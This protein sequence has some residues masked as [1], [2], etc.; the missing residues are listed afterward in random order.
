MAR[1]VLTED[2]GL[3][4]KIFS[5]P[6][7][8]LGAAAAVA[9]IYGVLHAD[10]PAVVLF[11]VV[12]FGLTFVAFG[13]GA[14]WAVRTLELD[15]DAGT[16]TRAW[17]VFVPWK[18]HTE[19]LGAWQRVGI[20]RRRR[21]S[22]RSSYT[23]YPVFLARDDQE[24]PLRSPR[25]YA[26]ARAVAERVAKACTLG[27]RDEAGEDV[28]ER[29]ANE[30]DESLR[31]RLKRTGVDISGPARPE[32]AKATLTSEMGTL[33]IDVPARGFLSFQGFVAAAMGAGMLVQTAIIWA[34]EQRFPAYFLAADAAVALGFIVPMAIRCLTREQVKVSGRS[35][36]I[37][38]RSL[39]GE[40]R[41]HVPADEI[42]ELRLGV[43]GGGFFGGG[44]AFV[45]DKGLFAFGSGL[46]D[47]EQRWLA[48][49][50][51]RALLA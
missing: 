18:R 37:I 11:M 30:L 1:V 26:E 22:G 8:G 4:A 28:V 27:V 40:K 16:I 44:V 49:E 43:L 25:D 31:D 21:R 47:V 45:S 17:G 51:Q 19:P 14:G 34:S 41:R 5:V 9:A 38:T 7:M 24:L 23:C 39:L 48:A 13:A 36:E 20:E 10:V 46:S 32:D 33:V 12:P 50:V 3:P 42:E 2:N 35:V 29:R 6:F 15:P